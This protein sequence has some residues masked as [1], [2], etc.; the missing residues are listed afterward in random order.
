VLRQHQQQQQQQFAKR[1]SWGQICVILY[2]L[3]GS[4]ALH[5][6][7]TT[8]QPTTAGTSNFRSKIAENCLKRRREE[9]RSKISECCRNLHD[10]AA[11]RRKSPNVVKICMISAVKRRKEENNLK[12]EV[13]SV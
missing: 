8:A 11:E 4:R 2:G 7:A 3:T 6:I 5:C 13:V 1:K 10:S 9:K 12:R